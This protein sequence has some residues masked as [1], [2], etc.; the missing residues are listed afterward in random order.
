MG[1]GAANKSLLNQNA[2]NSDKPNSASYTGNLIELVIICP[3]DA[4]KKDMLRL[5]HGGDL[6]KDT[7]EVGLKDAVRR[8]VIWDPAATEVLCVVLEASLWRCVQVVT[9]VKVILLGWVGTDPKNDVESVEWEPSESFFLN[10]L[11]HGSTFPCALD[12]LVAVYF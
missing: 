12:S 11:G 2:K 3:H 7:E 6:N 4:I 5:W 8:S 10:V 1:I 9:P